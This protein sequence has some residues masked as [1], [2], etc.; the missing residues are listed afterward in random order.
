MDDRPLNIASSFRVCQSFCVAGRFRPKREGVKLV[1]SDSSL[2]TPAEKRTAKRDPESSRRALI[3][4][5]LDT[6]AEIGITD[7][8]V[9][10]IIQRAGLSRG[11]IHL[12]FGGKNQLLAAA[13]RSFG[14]S[15]FEVLDQWVQGAGDDPEAIITAVI[16]ADLSETLMNVRST[17]IWHAFRGAAN[18]NEGIAAYSGTR[19]KRL[20]DIIN[21]AFRQ[22]AHDSGESKESTLARDATFGLLVLLEGMWVDY[23]SNADAFSRDVA[24]S[25]VRRFIAGLFPGRF[26]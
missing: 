6:I 11:M 5:T 17:R 10:K 7:T 13:A 21:T 20:H 24:I 3:L 14:E 2:E 15:Y 25:I 16:R 8:T 4:A 23:L 26:S 1:K 9:S 12:H 18:S 19:D 22:I